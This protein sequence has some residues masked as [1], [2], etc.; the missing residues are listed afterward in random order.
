MSTVAACRKKKLIRKA[1]FLK[2]EFLG[3]IVIFLIITYSDSPFVA[4]NEVQC[5]DLNLYLV[6]LVGWIVF[7]LG[8]KFLH[9]LFLPWLLTPELYKAVYGY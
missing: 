7:F 4:H 5:A 2:G 3:T 9:S 1:T 8:P 6:S